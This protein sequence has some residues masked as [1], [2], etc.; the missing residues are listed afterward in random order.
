MD[1][2]LI[3]PLSILKDAPQ[4]FGSYNPENYDREF[5]GPIRA[6]DA[7]ARSRN[8][9]AVELSSRL[10]HP[11]LY[12][13]LKKAG[14]RLPHDEKFYGL[15]LPLGGAEVTMQE[16]VRL[17]AVLAN[18][19]R[20]RT[21]HT[22]LPHGSEPGVRLLSPEAS[23]LTLEMLGQIPRP[24]ATDVEQ[25]MPVFWKTG[26]SNGFHDAWSVCVFDHYVLAVWVGNFDGSCNP[27]FIGRSCAGPLLFQMVDAMRGAGRVHH[28]THEPPPNANLR[29]VEFCA[30]SGELATP[31]CKHK[32]SGW[33]IPG[34]SPITNCDVHREVLVDAATGLRVAED[35]GTRK[36][37]SEVYEFWPSDLLEL[38]EKAGLPRQLPPPFLPGCDIDRSARRGTPPVIISPRSGVTYTVGAQEDASRSLSLRAQADTDA[39]KIYW[40]VDRDL[41]GQAPVSGSLT[42]K[43]AVGTHT[44]VALDDSGRSDSCLITVQATGMN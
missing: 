14:V 37:R 23:F 17:Y 27:V 6:A 34:V 40:F 21:L 28:E 38:F 20:L 10:A 39:R 19:G 11:V 13:F 24:S 7:L 9:P 5:I 33:F 43:P 3:H 12:E 4:S 18:N 8:I 15:T 25:E 42:W 32:V 41:V 2:G 22:T 29:R 1:Q 26:T 35:D 31:N 16:L 30:V 44:I 36:L